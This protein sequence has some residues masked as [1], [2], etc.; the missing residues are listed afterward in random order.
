MKMIDQYE[1]DILY[2]EMSEKLKNQ[3]KYINTMISLLGLGNILEKLGIIESI[4]FLF[5]LLI[6][7]LIIHLRII[8]N[9]NTV[10]YIATYLCVLSEHGMTNIGWEKNISKFK[11]DG[12]GIIE[13]NNSIKE[14]IINFVYKT[15]RKL[16]HIGITSLS[17]YTLIQIGIHLFGS[18]NINT[19]LKILLFIIALFL[20]TMNILCTYTI[21]VDDCIQK[22]YKKRWEVIALDNE[23]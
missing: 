3:D 15:G 20:L 5:I 21:F 2:K 6:I 18:N 11:A 9:R 13:N 14:K 7:T 12:Y 19:V 22:S 8:A 10:L 16:Q 17:I 1:Y 23:N 4:S